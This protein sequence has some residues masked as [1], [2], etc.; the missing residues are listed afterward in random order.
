MLSTSSH[1]PGRYVAVESRFEPIRLVNN[2]RHVCT[3]TFALYV[4]G[5]T[6]LYSVVDYYL[7]FYTGHSISKGRYARARS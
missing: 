3:M 5:Q 7:R 6:I 1:Y 2:D 4:F